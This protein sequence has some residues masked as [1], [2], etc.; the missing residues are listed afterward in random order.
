MVIHHE[1]SGVE[2]SGVRGDVVLFSGA[3]LALG[4]DGHTVTRQPGI[5]G[6]PGDSEGCW[7][8][9]GEVQTGGP[10]NSYRKKR[11]Y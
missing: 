2:L 1:S 3:V 11:E 8:D 7:T 10:R 5:R 4:G 6:R 9:L